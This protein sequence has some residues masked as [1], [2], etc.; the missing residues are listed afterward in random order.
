MT[1]CVRRSKRE[2]LSII[3]LLREIYLTSLSLCFAIFQNKQIIAT[4]QGPGDEISKLIVWHLM[5]ALMTPCGMQVVGH[6]LD[7]LLE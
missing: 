6:F 2:S 1:F 4:L 3:S 5:G 7:P